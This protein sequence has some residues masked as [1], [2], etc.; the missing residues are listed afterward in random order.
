[1]KDF[2]YF[3]PFVTKIQG[4]EIPISAATLKQACLRE[5]TLNHIIYHLTKK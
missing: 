5:K 1:M 3:D 2:I 4:Q